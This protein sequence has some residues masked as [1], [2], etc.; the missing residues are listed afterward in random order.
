MKNIYVHKRLCA[1]VSF[2]SAENADWAKKNPN[3]HP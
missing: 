1:Y 2:L 3:P